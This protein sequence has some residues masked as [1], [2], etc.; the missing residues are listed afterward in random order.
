MTPTGQTTAETPSIERTLNIRSALQPSFSPDGKR[1][2]FLTNITGE[3]QVW[4]MDA[5]GGWPEPF[6]SHTSPRPGPT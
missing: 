3:H 4:V 5:G 1:L 6:P 2:S